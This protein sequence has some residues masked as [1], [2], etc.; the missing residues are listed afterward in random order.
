MQR[1]ARV[2]QRQLS[3]LLEVL[4]ELKSTSADTLFQT[5]IILSQKK[6]LCIP[7]LYGL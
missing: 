1:V 6:E 2:C 7:E 3:Y 5:F 4:T